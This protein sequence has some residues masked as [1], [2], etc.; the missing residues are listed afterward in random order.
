MSIKPSS[1]RLHYSISHQ[2]DNL[3]SFTH[4]TR[5]TFFYTFTLVIQTSTFFPSNQQHTKSTMKTSFASSIV[6]TLLSSVA[7]GAPTP[8][9]TDISHAAVRDPA[10]PQATDISPQKRVVP[11]VL[12]TIGATVG[13]T[14]LQVATTKAMESGAELVKNLGDWT[15][16]R[17]AFTQATTAAMWKNNPDRAKYAAAICYNKGYSFANPSK[18]AGIKK[19]KFA[20]GALHTDY[21]CMYMEAGNAFHTASDGGFINVS[22]RH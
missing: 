14:V 20:L 18:V 9:Q 12:V 5:F 3:Q 7:N 21:D 19:A 15:E 11:V 10:L 1:H 6:L 17:E 4:R 16:A 22:C 13:A 2:L 8:V